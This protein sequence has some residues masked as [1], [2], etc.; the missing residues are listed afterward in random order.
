MKP[1]DSMRVELCK[2]AKRVESCFGVEFVRGVN[3]GGK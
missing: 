3:A 2:D 1:L